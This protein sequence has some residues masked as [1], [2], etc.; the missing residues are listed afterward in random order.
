MFEHMTHEQKAQLLAE[1]Q[2]ACMDTLSLIMFAEQEFKDAFRS[3]STEQ[4]DACLEQ[5]RTNVKGE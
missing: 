1:C 3:L 4:L 5:R 2:V